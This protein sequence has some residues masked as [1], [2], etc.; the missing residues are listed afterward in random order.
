MVLK[1]D[2]Q[3]ICAITVHPETKGVTYAVIR[4]DGTSPIFSCRAYLF[5]DVAK[6]V[7]AAVEEALNREAKQSEAEKLSFTENSLQVK[8]QNSR[9]RSRTALA[10][11]PLLP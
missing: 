11:L 8:A 4:P 6:L 5:S 3:L 1:I 7:R 10:T 2:R 9:A